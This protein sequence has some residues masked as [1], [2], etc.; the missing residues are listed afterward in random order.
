[1]E[2][3]FFI[4]QS[5]SAQNSVKDKWLDTSSEKVRSFTQFESYSI[6]GLSGNTN[7]SFFFTLEK[8]DAKAATLF[9]NTIKSGG[10][11]LNFNDNNKLF[12]HAHYPNSYSYLFDNIDLSKKNCLAFIRN[13]S[14]FHL[15]NYDLESQKLYQI[16][17]C[18]LPENI[19]ISG[20]TY[21]IGYN[22]TGTAQTSL[23]G[24]SGKFDQM[25]LFNQSID[26]DESLKIF[27][28]F[29][30]FSKTTT[31]GCSIYSIESNFQ[32]SSNP[33]ISDQDIVK[34]SGFLYQIR[35]YLP[36]INSQ[37]VVTTPKSY[38]ADVTGYTD[39]LNSRIFW[40]GSYF[41]CN[42]INCSPKGATIYTINENTYSPYSPPALS[43][44][45]DFTDKI[46]F[47]INTSNEINTNH[48]FTYKTY[49]YPN[50][51]NYLLYDFLEKKA[52]FSNNS[53]SSLDAS[54]LKQFYFE[55][56]STQEKFCSLYYY[57]SKTFDEIGISLPYDVFFGKF[58]APEDFQNGYFVYWGPTL[59][60]Y[61]L[62]GDYI[63]P[64][65]TVDKTYPMIFDKVNS[66]LENISANFFSTTG[67][68][69]KGAGVVFSNNVSFN[70]RNNRLNNK[71]YLQ[72]SEFSIIHNKK[73]KIT[74]TFPQKTFDNSSSGW[75]NI[76]EAILI[77]EQ[78]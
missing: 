42:G 62:N 74:S 66:N 28:G 2:L 34:L 9:S 25:V 37:C 20:G 58:I 27:S 1:M 46:L 39:H 19:K 43:G 45:I 30:P 49:N 38:R 11:S 68:Y 47:S 32:Q 78:A 35:N 3:D 12:F 57:P 65:T 50:I 18:I 10:F 26:F 13:E 21:T 22:A 44:R 60:S 51:N 69:P 70:Y 23:Y 7:F 41:E 72:T 64:N 59:I 75:G 71:D 55:G 36:D 15:L 77:P 6:T 53:F 40:S 48:F 54:Y 33:I 63:I 67:K 31:T 61:S 24:I 52:F 76:M 8:K 17:H 4:S 29:L 73:R 16:D 56:V 5:S 14:I